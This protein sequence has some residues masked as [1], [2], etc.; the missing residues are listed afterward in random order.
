M[1]DAP[2]DIVALLRQ[3]ADV[4]LERLNRVAKKESAGTESEDTED[5]L[6]IAWLDARI[7]L[8]REIEARKG[9]GTTC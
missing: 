9:K 8:A 3:K 4:C 7:D 6:Q 5:V 2:E 1:S